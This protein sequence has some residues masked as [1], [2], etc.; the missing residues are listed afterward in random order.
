MIRFLQT[1]R[2]ATK[3]VLGGIL[4]LICASMVLFMIPGIGQNTR[5]FTKAGVVAT[6]G[7]HEITAVEIR[8]MA[9]RMVQ[10]QFRGQGGSQFVPFFVQQA[11][12]QLIAS[13]ALAVQ[14]Q[15]MGLRVTDQEVFAELQKPIYGLYENGKFSQ[16][17][18][19]TILQQSNLTQEQAL[20]SLRQQMLVGKL[21][22]VV[23]AGVVVSNDEIHREFLQQNVRVK[24]DYALVNLDDLKKTIKPSDIELKAYFESVKKEYLNSIPEKRQVQ[25]VEL[26]PLTLPGT[27]PVSQQ[28]LQAYYNQ[29][30][31]E[32]REPDQ[33]KTSHILVKTPA[34][35]PDGKVDDKAVAA[36]QAK[37]EGLLKQIKAGAKFEDLAKKNSD[38]PG[39]AAQG[40]S[41]GWAR[42]GAFV[43]EFEKAAFALN[44]GQI[45]DVV[46][47]Q[48]GFHI[49]RLDDKQEAHVKSLDE[50]KSTIEP[51]ILRQKQTKAAE[52]LATQIAAEGQKQGLEAAAKAHGVSV[53][54]TDFFD[55]A[56]GVPGVGPVPALTDAVFSA[57][58]KAAPQ[59]VPTPQGWVI[60]T[61]TAVKP[62]ATPSFEEVKD[63][64]DAEFK[65]QRAAQL[66]SQK[67]QELA[68]K[69][70]AYKDLK[71]A[72][73][74]VG[75]T[76]KTSDLVLPSGQVPDLGSMGGPA[77]V[78]F[79]MKAGDVSL[80]LTIG[81]N[82][83]VLM[84]L[85][86]QEPAEAD[87]DAKKDT[88][89]DE[90]LGRKKQEV[91]RVFIDNLRQQMEK[92]GTIKVNQ[93]ELKAMTGRES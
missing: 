20:D 84:L 65:S 70:K 45:S 15:R 47:S 35:G 2:A 39:S 54:S 59:A 68:D 55:R 76:F 42:R 36:A 49:I 24:F 93:Q 86:H 40:G 91:I 9:L 78:A 18:W 14:A 58:E 88:I 57:K 44:K 3:Y 71:R 87:Y 85:E 17:R 63:K 34:P 89:K 28:E 75:A 7:D 90:L 6:V 80:P 60:F 72:A 56:S 51:A 64:V 29:H 11:A 83:A 74:E 25:V 26:S 21:Q 82:G 31:N 67:T 52:T 73:K 62:P 27:Q 48:F 66:V 61:V 22:T 37:A 19:E 43:P 41:L 5:F 13:Q 30:I 33:V 32:Y 16:D 92:S 46:K 79:S 53:R 77:N 38:D 69:A 10:Q 50:V 23:S 8:Q 12:D 4:L 81:N 1:Q